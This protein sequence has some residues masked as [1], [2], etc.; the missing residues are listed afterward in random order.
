M[1]LHDMG[2]S[3]PVLFC[4]NIVIGWLQLTRRSAVTT[5]SAVRLT[6]GL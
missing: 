2:A 5:G 4:A 6:P 1:A 3:V